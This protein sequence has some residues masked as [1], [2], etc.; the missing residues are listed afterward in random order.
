MG[1]LFLYLF[2]TF[3]N[4]AM[5]F[6]PETPNVK[7]ERRWQGGSNRPEAFFWDIYVRGVY[8]RTRQ[9]PGLNLCAMGGLVNNKNNSTGR[10]GP[11][12]LRL[13]KA[14]GHRTFS[15]WASAHGQG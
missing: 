5:L 15:P 11:I 1:Y 6:V 9:H 7:P 14:Y 4:A 12:C 8:I 2:F 10:G 3:A 13:G